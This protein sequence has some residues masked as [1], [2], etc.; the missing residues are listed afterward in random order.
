[1]R[2]ARQEAGAM[3]D[4]RRKLLRTMVEAMGALAAGRLTTGEAGLAQMTPQP[5]P[6]PNAPSNPNAPAGLDAPEI[7]RPGQPQLTAPLNQAQIL[8]WVEQLY[9]LT[10]ELK[11]EA[12]HT[13]LATVFPLSFV[14][15]AQQIEKLAKQIKNHAKGGA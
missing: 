10:A 6:S 5:M 15:K 11:D 7:V 1:M 4:A 9:K 13:N 2:S 12:E 8:A 3:L 14:K